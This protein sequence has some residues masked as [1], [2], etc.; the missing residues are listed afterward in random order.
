MNLFRFVPG[1]DTLY[2]AGREPALLMFV[3]FIV[4]YACTRFYTR[5]GRKRGW[6]SGS[7]GGVHLH[8]LVPGVLMSLAAGAL[9][10]AFDP[11]GIPLGLLA[12]VFGAG[13]ALTL[14]EFALVLH[15]DDVYWTQEG[16]TSIDACLAAVAFL[17]LTLVAASPFGEPGDKPG[18]WAA[19]A[20]I[21]VV[22]L[23]VVVTVLKGKLTMGL[24]ALVF[25][26]VAL[27]GAL[28]LA[29][30]RSIWARLLYPQDGR[31]M[32]RSLRRS[33]RRGARWS[34]RRNRFYDLIGGAP[35]LDS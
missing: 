21:A 5:M 11:G 14:D 25:P 30:P 13:A 18:R 3:A 35:N 26:P 19:V 33:E 22:G 23:F 20:A 24:L 7:V 29:K 8:H 27:V 9:V 12:I 17:G 6:G 1:Y 10:I 31:R 16:R 34:N 4:A 28:R 2:E 15:L 32:R